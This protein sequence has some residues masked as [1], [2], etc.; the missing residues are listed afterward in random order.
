MS[1]DR[2]ELDTPKGKEILMYAAG[3]EQCIL[4]FA[5]MDDGTMTVADITDHVRA[6]ED[7]VVGDAT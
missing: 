6:L 1:G 5:R 2:V 3:R 4:E 7:E